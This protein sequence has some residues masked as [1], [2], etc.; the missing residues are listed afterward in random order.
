VIV[1]FGLSLTTIP[2]RIFLGT[3]FP[4]NKS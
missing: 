4:L 3:F 1:L 2:L